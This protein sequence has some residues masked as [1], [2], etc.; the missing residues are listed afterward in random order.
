M[1]IRVWIA[2]LHF[3]SWLWLYLSIWVYIG[4]IRSIIPLIPSI[5]VSLKLN[6]FRWCWQ[7]HPSPINKFLFLL[8]VL[9]AFSELM[10]NQ[11]TAKAKI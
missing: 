1:L 6:Q 10:S 5:F 11:S 2:L 9:D 4:Y 7:F 3:L 8:L